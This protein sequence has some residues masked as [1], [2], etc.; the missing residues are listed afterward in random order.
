MSVSKEELTPGSEQMK[1]RASKAMQRMG[2]QLLTPLEAANLI[3]GNKNELI[4][5]QDRN[6]D[7]DEVL[8]V[9]VRTPQQRF[10]HEILP[11]GVKVRVQFW[12]YSS[13]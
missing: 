12:L 5:S 7:E 11:G 10:D 6:E 8:F 9:D 13:T 2:K 3:A 1:S 4:N